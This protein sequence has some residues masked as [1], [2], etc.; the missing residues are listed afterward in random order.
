[1]KPPDDEDLRGRL[2]DAQLHLLDRQVIDVRG[3]PIT[4]VD[5]LELTDVPLNEDLPLDTPAPAIV[6]LLT[7][8]V[9]GTR[10]FGGRPPESRLIRTPWSAV[11]E[12]GVAIKL[13]VAGES[14]DVTWTE[15]WVRDKII[16]RIPGARHDPD[17]GGRS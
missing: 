17:E 5:D 9:L 7:G 3:A 8:P 13:A 6:A 12:I 15:R 4:T 11:L 2:L 16:G 10:I 1:M 14:L